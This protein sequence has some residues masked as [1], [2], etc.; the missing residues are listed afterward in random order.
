MT[1]YSSKR[2]I[3]SCPPYQLYMAFADMRNFLQYVPADK[4]QD[5]TADYDTINFKVQGFDFG[6]KAYERV[7]YS[8]LS[9]VDN[10]AP[11]AFKVDLCFDSDNGSQNTTDFHI[12]VEADLNFMMKMM[13]GSKI[14]DGLDKLVDA[15][16]DMSNGK[17]PEGFDPSQFNGGGDFFKK[18]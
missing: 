13:I 17:V 5:V 8:R 1:K 11:F 14:K 16:A 12:E 9:F 6:V 10:G 7:P 15:M 4:K 18:N 3:V 2:G